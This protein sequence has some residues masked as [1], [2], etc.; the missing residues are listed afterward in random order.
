MWNPVQKALETL[1]I[2]SKEGKRKYY[3]FRPTGFYGGIATADC[4]GCNLRCLFCWS[5]Q[6]IINPEAGGYFYTPAQVAGNLIRI[7]RQKGFHKVRISGSEPTLDREHLITILS[8]IPLDIQFILETN[9]ILIGNDETYAQEL[10]KF[11][12]LRVRV[13]F[14]GAT[15]DEFSQLTQADPQA[16]LLQV[17]AVENLFRAKVRVNPAL[18]SSF[19]TAESIKSLQQIL[20]EIHPGLMSIE[21]EQLVLYGEVQ[22]RLQK[23]GIAPVSE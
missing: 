17:K 23:A 12:N 1:P 19:S 22:D 8:Q 5:W 11:E 21:M 15:P 3:R 13:S 20:G 18:M 16:F 14:K 2:V 9:G 10:A 6:N 4:V 7:A